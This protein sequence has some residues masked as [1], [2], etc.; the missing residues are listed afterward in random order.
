[1]QEA[2]SIY[3]GY[4]GHA[5]NIRPNILSVK[6]FNYLRSSPFFS[7][8]IMRLL[9]ISDKGGHNKIKK[10]HCK[11]TD[12]IQFS[13]RNDLKKTYAYFFI[14]AALVVLLDQITKCYINSNVSI[15]G[16]L[17][18]V[19]GLFNI[20]H[21]RNTGA[22][23]GFLAGAAPV[24]RCFF[25]IAVTVAA[26][27][28]IIFYVWKIKAEEVF[29]NFSLSLILGGAVGNLIDRVRLGE[30]IDFLDFYVGSYHWPAFNVADSAISVGAVILVF[31]IFKGGKKGDKRG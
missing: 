5:R 19:E 24:F 16:S 11:F 7:I 8:I 14:V 27:F 1:M 25:L 9:Y 2:G 21:V 29:F 3:P 30:V 12:F 28:L 4:P 15:Y 20:T 23:F 18:V 31:S 6:L 13:R 10:A 17:P 22:A 26:I